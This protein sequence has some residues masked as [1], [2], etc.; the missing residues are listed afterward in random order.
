MSDSLK[1]F[2]LADNPRNIKL[3]DALAII[4][5]VLSIRA[6]QLHKSIYYGL[7][8]IHC[9]TRATSKGTAK[10]RDAVLNKFRDFSISFATNHLEM[11]GDF[12]MYGGSIGVMN[13]YY[14]K[15]FTPEGEIVRK[16]QDNFINFALIHSYITG[17]HTFL[18]NVYLDVE[19]SGE[20]NVLEKLDKHI[21]ELEVL[22]PTVRV[23]IDE[24]RQ[25]RRQ[26]ETIALPSIIDTAN[27][28]SR[29]DALEA[30]HAAVHGAVPANS[31]VAITGV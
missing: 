18:A 2:F 30:A 11:I 4:P 5:K 21:A 3:D 26:G 10:Y 8:L 27:D 28:E 22:R 31:T 16:E 14:E 24:L 19:D 29:L 9:I 13:H 23:A 6:A 17:F 15:T 12:N 20:V 25:L 7:E 1:Y